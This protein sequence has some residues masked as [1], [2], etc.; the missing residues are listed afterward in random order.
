MVNCHRSASGL[1]SAPV[2][3]DNSKVIET[4]EK[5]K[6][7]VAQLTAVAMASNSLFSSVTSCQQNFFWGPPRRM[8]AA[9]SQAN[10]SKKEIAFVASPP[11]PT[12]ASLHLNPDFQTRLPCRTLHS[13]KTA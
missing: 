3:E 2:I 8:K 5:Q 10:K 12:T 11:T 4:I 7:S 6:L 1:R 9:D 13:S